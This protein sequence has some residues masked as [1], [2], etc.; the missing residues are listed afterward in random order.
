MII[1]EVLVKFFLPHIL[2]AGVGYE[3][4]CDTHFEFFYLI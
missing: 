3:A 4:I 1:R 2:R